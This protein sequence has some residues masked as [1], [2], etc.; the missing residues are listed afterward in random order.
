[1]SLVI[2]NTA[3]TRSYCV[4]ITVTTGWQYKTVTIPPC[5]DGVW[6]S[7][8]TAAAHIMFTCVCGTTYTAPSANAW[9]SGNYVAAPG[10]TS[11]FSTGLGVSI[12]GVVVLPGVEAPSATRSSLIMRPYDQELVTCQRYWRKVSAVSGIGYSPTNWQ[13]TIS[14]PGMRAVPVVGCSSPG[15]NITDTATNYPQSTIV[16]GIVANL[17]STLDGGL[18][19]VANYS[20]LT[21]NRVYMVGSGAFTVDARL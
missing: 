9:L 10:Q 15:I 13:A 20:G 17:I 19:N 3:G 16:N 1:M 12:T 21:P 14:C 11:I 2:K 6:G 5:P 4:P 7:D 18:V 8:N